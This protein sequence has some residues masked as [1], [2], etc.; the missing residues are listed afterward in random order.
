[1]ALS[2]CGALV[3]KNAAAP[4]IIVCLLPIKQTTKTYAF[5]IRNNYHSQ[6]AVWHGMHDMAWHGMP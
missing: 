3:L 2:L 4:F 1:M 6:H 5:E